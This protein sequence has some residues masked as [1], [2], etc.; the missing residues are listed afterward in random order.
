[1]K[2]SQKEEELM[3]IIWRLDAVYMKDIL[4]QLPEPKPASTTIATLLKRMIDKGAIGFNLNG[5][6]RQYYSLIDKKEYSSSYLKNM[7]ATF[8]QGS[9]RRFA[10]FFTNDMSLSK[11]ELLELRKMIDDKL[12]R[13]DS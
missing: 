10:S 9:S 8:F 5:N 6:S 3:D 13:S 11:E 7:I 2:L 1:M 4:D 12:E